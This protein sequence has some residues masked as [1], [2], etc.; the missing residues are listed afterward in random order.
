MSFNVVAEL[1]LHIVC[2]ILCATIIYRA[3]CS[4]MILLVTKITGL[5][6]Q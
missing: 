2:Q 6:R 5:E 1:Q 4:W 3:D